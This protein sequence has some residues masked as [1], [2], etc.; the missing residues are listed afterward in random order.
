MLLGVYGAYPAQI[1]IGGESRTCG[2]KDIDSEDQ[3]RNW[4]RLIIYRCGGELYIFLPVPKGRHHQKGCVVHFSLV[5]ITWQAIASHRAQQQILDWLKGKL[6]LHMFLLPSLRGFAL[7]LCNQLKLVDWFILQNV[8]DETNLLFP[9]LK[10]LSI[11]C[12]GKLQLFMSFMMNFEWLH[13]L[14]SRVP[15]IQQLFGTHYVT[16]IS[17]LPF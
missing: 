14:H 8:N 9:L 11:H 4:S 2:I 3:V 16:Y 5:H 12:V 15:S 10:H 1:P 13:L 6:A 7:G 17:S